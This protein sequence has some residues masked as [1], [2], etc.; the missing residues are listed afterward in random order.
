MASYCT[1]AEIQRAINKGTLS[2]SETAEFT[3]LAEEASRLIDDYCHRPDG[4]VALAVAT[5]RI[6]AGSGQRWQRIDECADV[7]LVAVKESITDSTYTAWAPTDWVKARGSPQ[8]P[9]YNRAPYDLLITA[10][11]GSYS[12]FLSARYG[13][14]SGF[15]PDDDYAAV[16]VPTV[17]VTAKW[18][19]AVTCPPEIRRAAIVQCAVWW[20]RGEG[21]YGNMLSNPEMGTINYYKEL[22]P[23]VKQILDRGRWVRE[24]V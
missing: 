6:Y 15:R 5:A 9:E 10:A 17:Q 12:R 24:V 4:F 8:R 19:Y 1:A 22:D 3:A 11:G 20:K 21:G 18:G 2:A 14:P 13:A 7:T 23:I 16:G